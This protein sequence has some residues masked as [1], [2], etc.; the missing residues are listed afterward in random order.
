MDAF[1][2]NSDD[3]LLILTLCQ[4]VFFWLEFTIWVSFLMTRS[5]HGELG[6]NCSSQNIN[7]NPKPN[8]NANSTK[9]VPSKII[10][11]AAVFSPH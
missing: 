8:P 3:L 4:D 9:V 2:L 5:L 11:A 7:R 1:T 10:V 6:I